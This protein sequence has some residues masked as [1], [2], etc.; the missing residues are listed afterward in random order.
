VEKIPGLSW[1]RNAYV[2]T[3]VAGLGFFLLSFAAL[4]VWPNQELEKQ[5]AAA[6]P[7]GLP[8]PSA[9]ERRGRLV[10]VRE[11]CA[12]CHSLLVRF[13]E[14]DV[15][16][17][18]PPVQAWEGEEDFPQ[19]WG[20]RR[21]GPDLSREHGRHPRDWQLVHLWNP[22][23][24]V[25]DSVMPPHTWLFDGSPRRPTQDAFDLAAFLESL[26]RDARLAGLGVPAPPPA[27]SAEEEQR[28]GMFC[29]CAIQRTAGP[30][31]VFGVGTDPGERARNERRG[32][33]VFARDCAGCHGPRGRGDGP[34][35]EALLPA[36]RDLS[37]AR[38]GDRAL[39]EA[40]WLG[41]PG[42]SMP[43]FND[44]PAAELRGLVA[45][46]QSLEAAGKA[47]G[48]LTG[49]ERD[50][51]KASYRLNCAACHGADGRGRELSATT[52]APPPTNFQQIRPT[53]A[54]AEAVLAD[55]VPGTAMPPW[56]DKLNDAERR[57]LARY[58]RSLYPDGPRPAE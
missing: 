3:A 26:G 25:P 53:L 46:V 43:P 35:A 12:N 39:S 58:V 8:P 42:S 28:R 6:R 14:D 20:T 4:A 48:P 11:G 22:R 52:L 34:A 57:L 21:I 38:F 15:R 17:F 13:T 19:L 55:G 23:W 2:L 45:F 50:R 29:D 27:M 40:L 41:V 47:D 10:Y 51:V 32:A 7:A 44:L 37:A 16:R 49:G 31:P 24:V 18:G 56:K 9:A 36:P 54:Y 30:A 1:L 33:L 5:I